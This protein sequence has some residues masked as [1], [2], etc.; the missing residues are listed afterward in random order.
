MLPLLT[1]RV[2]LLRRESYLSGGKKMMQ[3]K[4]Q[5]SAAQNEAQAAFEL[6]DR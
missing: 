4:Q 6:P 2:S 1:V 5:L 3:E